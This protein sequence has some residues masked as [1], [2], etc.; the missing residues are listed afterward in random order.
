MAKKEV[1]LTKKE[2]IDKAI[3][4]CDYLIVP[5]AGLCMIWG[6]DVSVYCAAGFGA[7]ASILSFVKLFVKD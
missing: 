2:I 6:V 3:A 5:V 4:T 7:I 1:K